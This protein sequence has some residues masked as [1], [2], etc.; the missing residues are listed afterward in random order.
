MVQI[1]LN[2]IGGL[3][4]S[5]RVNLSVTNLLAKWTHDCRSVGFSVARTVVFLL[6]KEMRRRTVMGV[7]L[8]EKDTDSAELVVLGRKMN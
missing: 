8:K 4:F 7:C 5:L 6:P 3:L 2:M 1:S